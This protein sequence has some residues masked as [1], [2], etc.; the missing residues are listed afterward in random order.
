[1]APARIAAE[2]GIGLARLIQRR[3]SIRI[4]ATAL[5]SGPDQRLPAHAQD[6]SRDTGDTR[7]G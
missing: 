1:M 6:L 5:N 7:R 2:P 4:G 3:C